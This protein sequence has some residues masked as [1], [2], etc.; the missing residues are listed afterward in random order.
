MSWLACGA[1]VR[2]G[3]T[4]LLW[5]HSQTLTTNIPAAAEKT[6]EGL[7]AELCLVIIWGNALFFQTHIPFDWLPPHHKASCIM[8]TTA[9]YLENPEE[10]FLPSFLSGQFKSSTGWHD[11]SNTQFSLLSPSVTETQLA[12][13]PGKAVAKE[14]A[15]HPSPILWLTEAHCWAVLG[16]LLAKTSL[17]T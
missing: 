6:S 8:T 11:N 3:M 17:T 2:K 14:T 12:G 15:V 4:L 1:L 13:L 16:P 5:F 9:H 10:A 7:K